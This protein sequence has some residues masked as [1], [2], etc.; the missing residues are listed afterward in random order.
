MDIITK[1]K[2]KHYMPSESGIDK[3]LALVRAKEMLAGGGAAPI[4]NPDHPGYSKKEIKA[5]VK[6]RI[7]KLKKKVNITTEPILAN[8]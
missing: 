8:E 7:I 2:L 1:A 4:T 3:D 5:S 6:R